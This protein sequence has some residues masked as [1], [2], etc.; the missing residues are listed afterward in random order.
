MYPLRLFAQKIL[1]EWK[2]HLINEWLVF[3]W[4]RSILGC[5]EETIREKLRP[6]ISRF[7]DHLASMRY[8][9]YLFYNL[10][11]L[12]LIKYL[13]PDA[14]EFYIGSVRKTYEFG[15]YVNVYAI[16]I[17]IPHNYEMDKNIEGEL[18]KIIL[19]NPNITVKVTFADLLKGFKKQ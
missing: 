19:Q 11:L 17:P 3:N 1:K 12:S 4:D 13:Q 10:D 8:F 9:K 14:R 6:H 18:R 2:R 15:R 7:L 5:D 16:N